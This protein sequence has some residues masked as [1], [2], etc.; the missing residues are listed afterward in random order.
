MAASE[1]R[2]RVG[3]RRRRAPLPG[4]ALCAHFPI[5]GVPQ[6]SGSLIEI[7]VFGVKIHPQGSDEARG[8]SFGMSRPER[9]ADLRRKRH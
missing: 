9:G 8:F 4:E 1:A 7:R 6:E 5:N 2:S 3:R